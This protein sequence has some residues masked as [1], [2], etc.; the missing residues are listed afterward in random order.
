VSGNVIFIEGGGKSKE[1]RT[2]CREG[3]H[4]LFERCQF[5]RGIRLKARGGRDEAFSS[6]KIAHSAKAPS[7]YVAMLIDSEEPVSAT[8]WEH[9][10]RR[11]PS[12]VRPQGT[13]DDQV[14]FMTTCMETW[15]ASDRS[16]LRE[17]YGSC[18]QESALPPG[19]N[20]ERISRQD[21]QDRLLRATKPC[22][23]RAY[24]KGEQS[25]KILGE[26]SS[27]AL[28]ALPSFARMRRILHER[29]RP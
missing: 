19:D 6:F 23:R 2:R 12:W 26:L 21:V 11:D 15:I 28:Q 9:L 14:L 18:L 3:F 22:G 8:P 7:E 1:L 27:E 4:K 20:L 24:K 10:K 13:T 29:L 16:A 17:H 25:F 5:P